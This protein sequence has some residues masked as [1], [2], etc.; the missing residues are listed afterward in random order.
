M[1][2]ARVFCFFFF[3]EYMFLPFATALSLRET[4]TGH[5]AK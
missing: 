5:D 4:E 3:A 2:F 1:Y